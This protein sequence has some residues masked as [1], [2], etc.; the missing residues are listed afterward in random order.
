MR[1]FMIIWFGQIFSLMGTAVSQFGLTLWAYDVS[2]GK[3]TPMAWIG[4]IFTAAMLVFSPFIGVWVDRGNRKLLMM[5]SDLA[6][7]FVTLIVLILYIAGR[8]Q[9]WHLYITAFIS[10]TFQG[11]QWPAYSAAI[12]TMLDKRHYARAS[13]M[14]E[15]IGPG[16]QI[17]A[18]IVAGALIGPIG[19]WIN[20]NAPTLANRLSGPPGIL[21]LL[22]I[23]LI[24][25]TVAIGTLLFVHIPQPERSEAGIQ[26]QGGFI[27]EIT[28]GLRYILQRPSLLALQTVFLV[29][30][31]FSNIGFA[32]Y[33]AMILARTNQNAL[34]FGGV[35]TA[36]AVGGLIGGIVL[37]AWGG[38]KR[39]V[40]GILLGWIV[41]GLGM[42]GMG[43]SQVLPLWLVFGFLIMAAM[44]LI[45]SSN[46]A[47]WQSKVPP[48]IQGRVFTSRRFIAW[49]AGPIS[50]WI[51][52][53]LADQV[54]EPAMR[55][56]N[57][58]ATL[59][60]W[61]VGTGSGAGMG[62][63]FAL[64]GVLSLAVGLG[65]YLFP[66]VRNAEDRLPDHDEV[67]SQAH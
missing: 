56:G 50:Q 49:L 41:S 30:N 19:L 24:S 6:A 21:G 26:A 45:N 1:T 10:G 32:V 66:A 12:S 22:I 35:Q 43:I 42:V 18:P 11:F 37:S 23:D 65:A 38:F 52:G 61:L 14:L 57:P 31:L 9:I 54:F 46:Q 20:A 53:P 62:L 51:A 55:P 5:L 29:G 25:A 48:D 4:A 7:A 28:F 67:S 58:L 60:G 33:A 8:L 27:H 15:M 39:R 59:V 40:H 3:A 36:S 16:S 34:I 63:Q 64:C 47:I 2:G 17:F 44:P 13:A